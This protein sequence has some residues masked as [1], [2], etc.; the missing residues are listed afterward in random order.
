MVAIESRLV[1]LELSGL[2]GVLLAM[3]QELGTG[4]SARI[5]VAEILRKDS[6][7]RL[8]NPAKR[9]G[10]ERCAADVRGIR[11]TPTGCCMKRLG[12]VEQESGNRRPARC[13]IPRLN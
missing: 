10:L 6:R 4:R 2:I 3:L 7:S 11:N 5:V 9:E 1:L 12:E 8:D 13:G